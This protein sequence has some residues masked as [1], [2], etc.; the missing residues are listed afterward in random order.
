MNGVIHTP[1]LVG[2]TASRPALPG[3][4]SR[5]VREANRG[6][7]YST[8]SRAATDS[9][10]A[11]QMRI[12]LRGD[13]ADVIHGGLQLHAGREYAGTPQRRREQWQGKAEQEGRPS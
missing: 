12:A 13:E 9:D 7:E 10:P 6:A 2:S 8:L 3:A 1:A 4:A 5:A 11:G